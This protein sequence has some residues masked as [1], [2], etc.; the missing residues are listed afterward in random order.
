M[1]P[2]FVPVG[3]DIG[4]QWLDVSVEGTH[5]RFAHDAA[6]YRALIAWLQ[7][8][9]P[10]LIAVEASGV[11]EQMAT[12]A[13]QAAGLSVARINPRQV[14]DFAKA[15]GKLAKTDRIDAQMLAAY[16]QALRPPAT[17]VM[18]PEQ[19]ELSALVT[20][21][22]QVMDIYAEEQ[23]RLRATLHAAMREDIQ[24]HLGLLKERIDRL[25]HAIAALIKT[26]PTM[27]AAYQQLIAVA[28]IGPVT[29]AVLIAELPE[30]GR[31]GPAQI[32]A[33]V[34]VAP[35]NHDSGA[36]RGHRHIRGG[37]KS[38]RCV[39]YMATISALRCNAAIRPFYQRLR[40]KGKPAKVAITAAMRKLLIHLNAILRDL[41][42]QP[43]P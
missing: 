33:L 1:N 35:M 12:A 41:Y 34:G 2:S 28:G 36:M 32:A 18:T 17:A 42:A 8:Q 37:R 11:Y 26:V 29:A 6:G 9:A 27:A 25:N 38:V 31:L 5:R 4:K 20:R 15:S 24:S 40:D 43:T 22:R 10:S 19:V 7:P 30:L 39:L 14:R 16:A 23:L 21:R 3:V 13:L